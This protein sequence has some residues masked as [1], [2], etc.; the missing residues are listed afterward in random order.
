M[1]I[2]TPVDYLKRAADLAG[3]NSALAAELT[4]VFPGNPV[5]P[6]RLFNWINRDGGAPS[7]FCAAIEGIVNQQVTRDQLHPADWQTIWPE[8]VPPSNK[9]KPKYAQAK[10]TTPALQEG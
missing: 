10:K 6:A 2:Q 8:Y 9:G 3:G 7:E 5:S 4:K 1:M